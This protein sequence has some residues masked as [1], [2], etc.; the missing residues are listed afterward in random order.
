[1]GGFA[2]LLNRRALQLAGGTYG[3]ILGHGEAHVVAAVI[4][5]ELAVQME[6]VGVPARRSGATFA[7]QFQ[8]ANLREPL[9]NQV[10][11]AVVAGARHHARKL[12]EKVDIQRGGCAGGN[13]L[14]QINAHHAAVGLGAVVGL[15]EAPFRHCTALRN[16]VQTDVAVL[17]IL[18]GYVAAKATAAG[19][20]LGHEGA[21]GAIKP[22]QIHMQINAAHRL[23]TA[24]APCQLLLASQCVFDRVK[25]GRDGIA[26]DTV[27]QAS[28]FAAACAAPSIGGTGLQH[29]AGIAPGQRNR[30]AIGSGRGGCWR[31]CF[32]QCG[33]RSQRKQ[34]GQG[35][36]QAG[37]VHGWTSMAGTSFLQCAMPANMATCRWSRISGVETWKTQRPV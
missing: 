8:H 2:G 21:A 23:R 34:G 35:K 18:G 37:T 7:R 3:V 33:Q 5:I 10:E 12:V 1:M 29:A 14:R 19:A 31:G 6:F 27:R 13:R 26:N 28:F 15:Y 30:G 36:D 32:G 4:G 25:F 16:L 9:A 20:L 11:A 22:I 24:V 17:A